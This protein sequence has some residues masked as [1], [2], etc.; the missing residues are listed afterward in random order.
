MRPV[1][2]SKTPDPRA[3]L[4]ELHRVLKSGGK[5]RIYYEDLDRYRG[6]KEKEASIY[7]L[8]NRQCIFE[9]YDRDPDREE[10][11]MI[12]VF[13][14]VSD[15][16][17]LEIMGSSESGDLDPCTITPSAIQELKG[18][19]EEIRVCIVRH[20]SEHTY[21]ELLKEAGFFR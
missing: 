15:E 10:A 19:I 9:L 18:K 2:S 3:I 13:L 17:M 16:E 1:L 12:K 21:V 5:L 14:R 20:P 7:K 6:K 11:T 8:G 4:Q